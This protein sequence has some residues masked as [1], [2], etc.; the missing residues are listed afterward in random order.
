MYHADLAL[1]V[2]VSLLYSITYIYLLH[3]YR[4]STESEQ[5]LEALRFELQ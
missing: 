4:A 2:Y 3:C 5:R 1:T